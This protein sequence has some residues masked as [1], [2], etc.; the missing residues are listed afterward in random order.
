MNKPINC[1]KIHQEDKTM[2]KVVKDGCHQLIERINI[3]VN[4]LL[5]TILK[6]SKLKQRI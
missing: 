4:H 5:L 2:D 3:G 6:I 1:M